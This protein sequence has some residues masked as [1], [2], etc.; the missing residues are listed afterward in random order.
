MPPA[1][2]RFTKRES[3]FT[4]AWNGPVVSG[5]VLAARVADAAC[6]AGTVLMP[7]SRRGVARILVAGTRTGDNRGL[8]VTPLRRLVLVSGVL[9]FLSALVG[10]AQVGPA[11]PPAP[12]SLV[13]AAP[14]SAGPIPPGDPQHGRYIVESIVMCMECHSPRDG[15]GRLIAGKEFTG[16]PIPFAPPWA[17]NWA[18]R[19]PRISGLPGYTEELAVRLLTQGAIDRNGVQLRPPMP[20]FRMTPQDAS[21]VVAYLKSLP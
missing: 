16:G 12:A 2:D 13:P 18:I 14:A 15:A 6:L 21:D 9:L 5:L 7:G 1:C 17:N 3:L 10:T 19:A 11:T 8:E 4:N 20:R